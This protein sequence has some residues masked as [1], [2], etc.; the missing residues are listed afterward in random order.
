MRTSLSF[1]LNKIALIRNSRNTHIPSVIEAAQTAISAGA[2]GIT[3][4]PRPD[5]RHIRPEDVYELAELL[6]R[7]QYQHIELNI[8]GNPY[9]GPHRNG[10]PGFIE[11][12]EQAAPEQCTLVPDAT[13]QLT[14]DHGWDLTLNSDR[15]I[16]IVNRLQE[17]NM[18]VSLFIDPKE[19]Q[20]EM[21]SKLGTDRVEF[22]TGPY[23]SYYATVERK[24]ILNTFS[25]AAEFA[26]F[27]EIGVNAGHDLNLENLAEFCK[28]VTPIHEVSI[29]HAIIVDALWLGLE[30]T[31]KRYLRILDHLALV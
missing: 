21:A 27:L 26:N 9:A 7:E 24:K 13:T 30:E 6:G 16:P 20:V 10:F 1:N 25:T 3:V 22:F 19:E 5:M 2:N 8:E 28:A 29:G 18:R 12:V 31:I 14:S 23:A 11:L 17:G 15:L 4:H